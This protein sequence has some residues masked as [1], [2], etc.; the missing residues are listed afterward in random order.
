MIAVRADV[1]E[2]APLTGPW[3]QLDAYAVQGFE[4]SIV[5]NDFRFDSLLPGSLDYWFY[6]GSLTTPPVARQWLGLF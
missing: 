2:D 3:L 1:D 6:E 4:N 5:V